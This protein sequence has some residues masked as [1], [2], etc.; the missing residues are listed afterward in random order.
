M[1]EMCEND[2]VCGEECGP[3]N[4]VTECYQILISLDEMK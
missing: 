4:E 3:V 2:G 1:N